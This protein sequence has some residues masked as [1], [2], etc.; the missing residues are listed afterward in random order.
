M[1]LPF[2]LLNSP[3]K[4]A[5]NKLVAFFFIQGETVAEDCNSFLL[6]FLSII[7]VQSIA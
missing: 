4:A 2:V 1:D 6:D 7:T 5:Y 3:K